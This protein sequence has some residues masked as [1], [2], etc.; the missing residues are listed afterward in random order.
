MDTLNAEIVLSDSNVR[1]FLREFLIESAGV[2]IADRIPS[3]RAFTEYEQGKQK[4]AIDLLNFMIYNC[5][6]SFAEM[7]A[8]VNKNRRNS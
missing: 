4:I 7:L 6:K 5:P 3:G 8:E 1:T 2:D